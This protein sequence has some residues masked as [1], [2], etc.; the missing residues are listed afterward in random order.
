M[1]RMWVIGAAVATLAAAYLADRIHRDAVI[2]A[3]MYAGDHGTRELL[4]AADRIPKLVLLLALG[5]IVVRIAR[6][7]ASRAEA[8]T[9]VGIGV[10]VGIVPAMAVT[11]EGLRMPQFVFDLVPPNQFVSWTGAGLLVLGVVGLMARRLP[12]TIPN[13]WS[14]AGAAV[15]VLAASWPADAWLNAA[16]LDATTS[17]DAFRVM[18]LGELVLRLGF[19]AALVALT[20][21]VLSAE[22]SVL[23]AAATLSAGLVVFIGFALIA[24]LI[25]T[26]SLQ[27]SPGRADAVPTTGWV[28]RWVAGAVSIL[29]AWWTWHSLRPGRSETR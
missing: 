18:L 16:F 10:V 28:G 2:N 5:W 25:L 26:P 22:R 12:S 29:G 23:P 4:L 8:W 19:M 1:R 13:R 20:W 17:V 21:V 11:L 3:G 14:S 7:G 6:H 9:L 24:V 15:L 27:V